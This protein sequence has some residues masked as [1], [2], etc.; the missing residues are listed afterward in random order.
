MRLLYVAVGCLWLVLALLLF[1][2]LTAL[3]ST[4][5]TTEQR[6]IAILVLA[7]LILPVA[8]QLRA[9]HRQIGEMTANA[10]VLHN[11]GIEVQLSG[12]AREWKGLPDVPHTTIPWSGVLSITSE[13][14]RFVYPS[15][16]PLGY[17]LTVFTLYSK[18]GGI[19][20]TREC[21]PNARRVAQEIA[22]RLGCEL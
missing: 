5:M 10:L 6:V 17:P 13:K 22:A 15:V 9:T 8:L 16:V 11:D 18:S 19:S 7:A 20:F 4:E 14:K 1:G 12:A 2:V 3:G 21:I